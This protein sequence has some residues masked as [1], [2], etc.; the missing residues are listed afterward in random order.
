MIFGENR[1]I[2][3]GIFGFNW[4]ILF[5]LYQLHTRKIKSRAVAF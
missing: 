3:D 2:F 1:S 4:Q 5:E